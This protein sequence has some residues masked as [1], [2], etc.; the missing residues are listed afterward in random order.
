MILSISKLERLFNLNV[1]K[2][3]KESLYIFD[4][5]ISFWFEKLLDSDISF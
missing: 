3:E 2:I 4:D 5:N 1:G